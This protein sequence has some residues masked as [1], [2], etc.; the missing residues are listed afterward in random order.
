MKERILSMA[1]ILDDILDVS[2]IT[3]Q[4]FTLNR[5]VVSIRPILRR[6]LESSRPLIE[7]RGHQ[8]NVS[9]PETSAMLDADATRL[10]Q[11]ITNLLNNAAKY[12]PHG[13]RIDLSLHC[14]ADWC[15]IKV[16]DSGVGIPPEMTDKIFERFV[17]VNP[18]NNRTG[19]IGLGLS[20]ARAL[21]EMHD[22]TIEAKSDGEGKGSEFV[23]RLPTVSVVKSPIQEEAMAL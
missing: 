14:E 20:L 21:V 10:E 8:L 1:H 23:V 7:S 13:G 12:T 3:Q 18:K 15:T 2:R 6:S 16:R 5:N 17:Q 19:G 9:L 22:G 4:K 11:V